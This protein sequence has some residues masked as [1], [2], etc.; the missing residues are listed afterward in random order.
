MSYVLSMAFR[1]KLM[2][3]PPLKAV[4]IYLPRRYGSTRAR[5]KK[6]A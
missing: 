2:S 1:S 3:K 4:G 6:G 5:N